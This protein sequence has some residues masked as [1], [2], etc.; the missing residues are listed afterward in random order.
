MEKWG[1]GPF[2]RPSPIQVESDEIMDSHDWV[3]QRAILASSFPL[4]FDGYRGEQARC[5]IFDSER[6]YEL[7][8]FAA[9]WTLHFYGEKHETGVAMLV[10]P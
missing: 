1:N 2:G 8:T 3:L 6:V 9:G 5:Q 10:F 4:G 7:K